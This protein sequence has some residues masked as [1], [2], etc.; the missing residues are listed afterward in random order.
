VGGR[1]DRALRGASRS[2]AARR[3]ASVTP[4]RTASRTAPSAGTWWNAASCRWRRPRCRA[5]RR[6]RAQTPTS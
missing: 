5:S 6:G 4:I 2:T 3:C 1:R